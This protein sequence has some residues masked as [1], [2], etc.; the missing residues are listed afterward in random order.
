VKKIIFLIIFVAATQVF[1]QSPQPPMMN[2]F[3]ENFNSS[4]LPSNFEFGT[5]RNSNRNTWT[6]GIESE[7][8]SETNVM[9]L[10]LHPDND[11]NPWQGP[12]FTSKNLTFFGR[13][14]A[15]IK[16]PSVENQPQVGGVVGF[17]TYYND[18]YNDEL[19]KDENEN[20]ISDNSE[21]DFEW[22]IANP[23]VV[24]MTAWTD[25]EENGTCRSIS[26]TVNLATGQILNTY[27][28]EKV[29]AWPPTQQLTGA[30]NQPQTIRPITEFDASK[31]FYVYGFDW[32]TDNIRWWIIDPN[33]ESDTIVLW[34]YRGNAEV[35]NSRISQK[36]AFVMFNFWHTNNWSAHGKP[37]STQKPESEFYAEFDWIRYE[38]LAGITK[39]ED[40]DKDNGTASITGKN[41]AAS[42]TSKTI[43]A[44]IMNRQLNLSFPAGTNNANIALYDIRGRLLFERDITVTTNFAGVTLPKSIAKNQM[45]I[46]QIK[47]NEINFAERIFVKR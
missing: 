11:A 32:K 47:T 14:S 31:N 22:L 8:E 1:A 36:P 9:R 28:S 26:R 12:N 24:Y 3:T 6:N 20:G 40:E 30:E 10:T 41:S 23:Q 34:N 38:T 35:G 17:F 43:N 44:S 15:R 29:G 2:S 25:Q 21:V 16:I 42:K 39:D 46:L 18:L 45:V 37:N 19:P 13:Y 33:D 4:S 5:N 27:Y 7:I